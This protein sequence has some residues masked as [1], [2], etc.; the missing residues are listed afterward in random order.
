MFA[1]LAVIF[2]GVL[3]V[4]QLASHASAE[5]ILLTLGLLCTAAA[6]A[7]GQWAPLPWRRG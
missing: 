4:L 2:F 6:L 7:F 3:F 1:L 5:L